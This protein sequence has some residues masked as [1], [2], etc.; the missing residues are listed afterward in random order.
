MSPC[1]WL[2]VSRGPHT[3]A[4]RKGQ[5]TRPLP[6]LAPSPIRPPAAT[7]LQCRPKLEPPLRSAVKRDRTD[8][9]LLSPAHE[10]YKGKT[11][12]Y[13]LPRKG[14]SP[15]C[16][17]KALQVPTICQT[18]EGTSY[19]SVSEKT[20]CLPWS[21]SHGERGPPTKVLASSQ[22]RAPTSVPIITALKVTS[23]LMTRTSNTNNVPF[24]QHNTV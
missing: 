3:R 21:Q 14:S 20:P 2:E 16:P 22:V 17:T 15:T 19:T 13:R 5:I 24:S 4:W 9:W 10:P 11:S 8:H 1:L 18:L 6:S 7:L 23:Y 12:E